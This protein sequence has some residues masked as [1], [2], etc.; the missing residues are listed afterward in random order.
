[1]KRLLQLLIIFGIIFMNTTS[2]AEQATSDVDAV[3]GPLQSYVRAHETGNADFIRQAFTKDAKVIGY[4]GGQ[5]ISWD[6][7]EYAARFS[8]K[9]AEDE[10]LR[11]RSFEVLDQSADAAVAKVVLDYPSVKFIDYMSL[12]KINGEWKIVA[13]SFHAQMKATQ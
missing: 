4:M 9:P 7:E 12:L 8:G 2:H 1:M 6:L 3:K 13:K 10:A 11:K 5:F